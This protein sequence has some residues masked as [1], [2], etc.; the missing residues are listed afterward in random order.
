MIPQESSWDKENLIDLDV[1]GK[2]YLEAI[3]IAQ[4]HLDFFIKVF[5]ADEISEFKFS[6][7]VR[8][9]DEK[10]IEHIWLTPTSFENDNFVAIVDNIP[11]NL[12]HIQYQ[13]TLQ[14]NRIDVEDWIINAG[15]GIL[16]GNFIYNS[17]QGK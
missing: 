4:K 1:T 15:D 12:T 8:F 13:E 6:I 14:I 11:N 7:K 17:L 16:I 3:Q 10:Y 9:E 5:I 2:S